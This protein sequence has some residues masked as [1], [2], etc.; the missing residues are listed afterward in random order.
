MRHLP[1]LLTLAN[2]LCGCLSIVCVLNAEPY[3]LNLDPSNPTYIWVH[4]TQQMIWWSGALIFLGALFDAF[5][6]FAARALKVHSPIGKDLDSLADVVT[7]GVA[8]SMIM[9]KLLWETSI[10]TEQT[11]VTP[12]LLVPAFAIAVFAALRLARF[13]VAP[14]ASGGGFTGLPTPAVGLL[15]ASF[16][17]TAWPGL[18]K[19]RFE[20]RLF[21]YIDRPWVLYL[22]IALLCWL[23]V[24][25]VRFIKLLPG[26]FTAQSTWPLL[27]VLLGG[28][29]SFFLF[30]YMAVLI[31]FVLYAIVSQIAPQP[32]PGPTL[33]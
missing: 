8:P 20:N 13:N 19:G 16:A 10:S 15:V 9:Y 22:I 3:L 12:F 31:A 21:S 6:G 23:M 1:N 5:D 27:V 4:G 14:P 11:A 30:G 28:V 24:S 7:F 2:L 18:D 29:A 33:S 32:K 25:K 26:R 17:M